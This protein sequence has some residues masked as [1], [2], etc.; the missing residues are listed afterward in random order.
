MLEF[1][2][3]PYKGIGHLIIKDSNSDEYFISN[4]DNW[5]EYNMKESMYPLINIQSNSFFKFNTDRHLGNGLIH[6]ETHILDLI[7]GKIIPV[8]KFNRKVTFRDGKYRLCKNFNN[9][10]IF[11]IEK[12]SQYGCNIRSDEYI[13]GYINWGTNWHKIPEIDLDLPVINN[14]IYVYGE[15]PS[16]SCIID[17]VKRELVKPESKELTMEFKPL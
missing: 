10:D 8:D 6:M 7:N 14:K 17:L 13:G 9:G 16:R 11:I 4:G 12:D 5:V 15:Y 1:Y 2:R 3:I